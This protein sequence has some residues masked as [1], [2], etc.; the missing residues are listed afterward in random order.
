MLSF[1]FGF[2]LLIF[3]FIEFFIGLSMG[4]LFLCVFCSYALSF[5]FGVYLVIND[6]A[7]YNADVMFSVSFF[8][9]YYVNRNLL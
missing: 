5:Y 7:H 8:N 3:S 1:F 2:S 9:K 6:P 4:F